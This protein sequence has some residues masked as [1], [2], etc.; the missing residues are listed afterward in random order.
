MISYIRKKGLFVAVGVWLIAT[1]SISMAI[2]SSVNDLVGQLK[3]S[4]E[5]ARLKAI[6]QLGAQGEKAAEA[7]APLTALL[8]DGSATVRSH[9]AGSLGEIGAPAKSA[10]PELIALLKDADDT[11][12]RQA[13]KALV[14]IRPGPR[15]MLP[16][17]TQLMRD[18]DPGVQMR[19]LNE[20]AEV[21]EAA[22]PG[23]I[24]ALK[25]DQT[26]YWACIVLREMGPAAKDAAPA[27]A[28]KLKDSRPE[29]RR[30]A[31]LALGAMKEAAIP[32]LPQIAAI[33]SDE[34]SKTAATFVL[35]QL[36]QIPAGSEE[37]IRKNVQSDDL[38][39]STVSLWALARVHPEDKELHRQA[40]QQ[41]VDRLKDQDP[42]VRVAAAR[43]LAALPPTPEITIP[44]LEKALR[45]AD[46]K[47]VHHALDALASLGAPAV[48]R[49]VELLNQ[50]KPLRVQLA[51]TLGQMGPAAAPATE[52]LAK[53]VGDEDVNLS[54]EAVL[55]LSKI[56][57]AAKGAVP[58]LSAALQKEKCPN[59]HAIIYALGKIGPSSA[60]A[61][62]L[63]Q[64]AL[65]SKD[66]SLAVVAAWAIT[67][68][69]P[70]SAQTAAKVVPVLVTGLSDSLPESRKAAAEALGDL[71]PL[72]R[73]ALPA[74]QK[75]TK[76][77]AK[78]VR[79][80]AEKALQS[81]SGQKAK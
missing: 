16:L 72:A 15:V 80:A 70:R 30:E 64:K 32:L 21:G 34:P 38:F 75:A 78:S 31:V 46:T 53:L 69:E 67:Q 19:I 23:L 39:L 76:D 7:V 37:I 13:V 44:I 51:Y 58:A 49:L 74:L 63:L 45:N 55:A 61:E 52:S 11:V 42:F 5:S 62:P 81:V 6:D 54:T 48:P 73:Q 28:E 33:V 57:P 40:T 10:A 14:A 79:E 56:G 60:S 20:I 43:A 65:G 35:G 12:R 50:Q 59:A 29:V 25:N 26:A 1:G 71:G 27:L 36:G 8:K 77:D 4:D 9:A 41:L 18:S 2:D 17:F 66:S 3:S 68:I 47:T 22:V 24:A